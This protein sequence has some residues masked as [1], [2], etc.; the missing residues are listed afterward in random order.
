MS[1]LSGYFGSVSLESTD[2]TMEWEWNYE[3]PTGL[4]LRLVKFKPKNLPL[5]ESIDW[6][7]KVENWLAG[8][9]F[10]PDECENQESHVF[11]SPDNFSIRVEAE[12][13]CVHM[14][15]VQ[16]RCLQCFSPIP[17]NLQGGANSFEVC[18]THCLPA[19]PSPDT[20]VE[21]ND[22]EIEK[23]VQV[24]NTNTVPKSHSNSSLVPNNGKDTQMKGIQFQIRGNDKKLQLKQKRRLFES[25]R[26]RMNDST[27]SSHSSSLE[28]LIRKREEEMAQETSEKAKTV[29]CGQCH[30]DL[31][32][33]RRQTHTMEGRA[34]DVRCYFCGHLVPPQQGDGNGNNTL[35]NN[36]DMRDTTP[37]PK[38]P[39]MAGAGNAGNCYLI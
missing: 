24:N 8:N 4:G 22:D 6:K 23:C 17:A 12:E 31:S 16:L 37:T 13:F 9:C 3:N 34:D 21:E 26:N 18:G 2:S 29:T 32:F 28:K 39:F 1:I 33:S 27:S 10:I 19:L 7:T 30:S 15:S 11:E 25:N 5:R 35:P 20:G 38:C 14:D 36:F